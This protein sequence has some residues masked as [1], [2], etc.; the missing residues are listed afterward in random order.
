MTCSSNP[1]QNVNNL[2]GVVTSS[3]HDRGGPGLR[4]QGVR[5]V[6]PHTSALGSL[7]G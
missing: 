4:W 3:T 6:L 1:G 5:K 2:L 7:D